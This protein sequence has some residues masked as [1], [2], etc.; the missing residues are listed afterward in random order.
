MM[1][2]DNHAIRDQMI[3]KVQTIHNFH[4]IPDDD[5]DSDWKNSGSKT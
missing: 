3:P 2:H 5:S 1:I 4:A